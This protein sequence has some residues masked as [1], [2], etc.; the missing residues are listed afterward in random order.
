MIYNTL[1][2]CAQSE[3]VVHVAGPFDQLHLTHFPPTPI[4]M[5]S[6]ESQNPSS[7]SIFANHLHGFNLYLLQAHGSG[8][9]FKS[10][11]GVP[12]LTY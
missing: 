3:F 11:F 9:N 8:F 2:F 1:C 4:L 10:L 6:E 12:H 7:L 5:N